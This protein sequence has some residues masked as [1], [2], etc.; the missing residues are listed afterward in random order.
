MCTQL[1]DLLPKS[2]L[3]QAELQ[4]DRDDAQMQLRDA[5]EAERETRTSLQEALWTRAD[6]HRLVLGVGWCR[7][8]NRNWIGFHEL[9][10]GTTVNPLVHSIGNYIISHSWFF[11]RCWSHTQAFQEVKRRI[12]MSFRHASFPT[13]S[14][15]EIWAF[16][17]IRFAEDVFVI[18]ELFEVIRWVQS[19]E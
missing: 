8:G 3:G 13:C 12:L 7:G 17:K 14:I 6:K 15:S 9:N 16:Q 2:V 18:F 1:V 11:G 4:A 10:I 5:V 19:Q